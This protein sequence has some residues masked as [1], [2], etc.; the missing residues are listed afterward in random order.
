MST[1]EPAQQALPTGTWNADPVHSTLGFSIDYMAGTF[2][3]TFA[4]FEARLADGKLRGTAD[5][6][7]V[8]V[9]DPTLEGHLQSPEFFDAERHPQLV[10]ESHELS[11][12]GDEATISGEITIKGHTEPI[13]L[14][15][16]ITD[17]I[18]DPFGGE[19]FGLKL[20]APV[21]RTKFDLNW[22]APLASGEPALSN[23]V[24]IMADLQ[25]VRET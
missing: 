17:P 14:H 15:G 6:G 23:E 7:S 2:Y 1:T 25:F 9:K 18:G 21:D 13:E 24:T 10:F 20:E 19:R 4:A 12:A 5:V 11:R 8:Q 16:T 3:G 22:N